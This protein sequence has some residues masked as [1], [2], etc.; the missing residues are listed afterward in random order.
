M[1]TVEIWTNR[2]DQEPEMVEKWTLQAD[3]KAKLAYLKGKEAR[4]P[5]LGDVSPADGKLYL[6]RLVSVIDNSSYLR[7]KVS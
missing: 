6:K 5:T 3:G 4:Y 1:N 2:P 7:A